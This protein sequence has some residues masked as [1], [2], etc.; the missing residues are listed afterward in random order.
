MEEAGRKGYNDREGLHDL[1][2]KV[3]GEVKD[4]FVKEVENKGDNEHVNEG[5]SNQLRPRASARVMR[6]MRERG[7][8]TSWLRSRTTG[9]VMASMRTH[10]TSV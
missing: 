9:R 1:V 4:N 6:S 2:V 7:R 3:K 10:K 5:E 8:A